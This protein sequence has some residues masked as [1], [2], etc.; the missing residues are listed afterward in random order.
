MDF[1]FPW[2]VST[3]GW[4]AFLSAT[5][6]VLIGFV[7]LFAPLVFLLRLRVWPAPERSESV[8]AMRANMAGFLLGVGLT[9]IV[10]DQPLIYLALGAC[11]AFSAAGR[12]ISIL[13]DRS[14]MLRN[15]GMIAVEAGLAAMPLAYV[16]G[17]VA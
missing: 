1:V 15:L 16:F 4:L 12:A 13:F 3:G 11:W 5:V 14:R 2:P 6:T 10:M 17:Y 8:S 9:S 7:S